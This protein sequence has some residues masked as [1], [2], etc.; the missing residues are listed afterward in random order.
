M[1]PSQITVVIEITSNLSRN[2]PDDGSGVWWFIGEYRMDWD[3]S[4]HISGLDN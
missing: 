4:I 3:K 1:T 2:V